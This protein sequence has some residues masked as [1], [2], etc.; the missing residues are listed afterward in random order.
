MAVNDPT[1]APEG[2]VG[3]DTSLQDMYNTYLEAQL[4]GMDTSGSDLSDS[5][6]MGGMDYSFYTD[7][8]SS[9][10]AIMEEAANTQIANTP[11]DLMGDFESQTTPTDWS[12]YED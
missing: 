4:A 10:A 11:R 7:P 6:Q 8:L 2:D 9:A 1:A 12:Y 5:S 3:V